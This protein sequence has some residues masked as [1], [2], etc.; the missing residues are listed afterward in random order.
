MILAVDEISQKDENKK[1]DTT[2]RSDN[3]TAPGLGGGGA[4]VARIFSLGIDSCTCGWTDEGRCGFDRRRKNRNGESGGYQ[5][6]RTQF[7]EAGG[8]AGL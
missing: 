6:A 7:V 3:E 2:N 4:M 8:V 1:P 5:L